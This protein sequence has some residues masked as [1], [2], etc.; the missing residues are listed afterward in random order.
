M[1]CAA[2]L[3]EMLNQF[4]T[5]LHNCSDHTKNFMMN[6]VEVLQETKGI[7]LPNFVPQTAFRTIMQRQVNHHSESYHQIQLSTR[8]AGHNLVA[9]MKE[10]SINWVTE[11]VQM[12][13]ETDYTCNPEYM[14]GWNK[15]MEQQQTVID[16]I[17]RYGS[18]K[19]VIDG[20]REVVVGDLRRYKHVLLQAFDLKMRL[21]AYWEIVLMRLVDNMALHLQLSIR[22]LVNK[23]MEK[24]IVTELLAS[25][26]EKLNTSINLPRES[27]EVM[28][29]IMD[30]IATAGD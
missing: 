2:R 28:A 23:E 30:E 7:E 12:E 13:K 27:Q 3:V 29:N 8:R 17:T 10:Q 20:P 4:S 22:N 25:K 15:L 26:R 14:K 5:E 9:K 16:N 6:E 21:I 11:I 18:S 19:V 1:H 24:E